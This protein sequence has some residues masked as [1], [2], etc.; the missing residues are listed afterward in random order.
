MIPRSPASR[1]RRLRA[2]AAALAA[3]ALLVLS[4]CGANDPSRNT[5]AVGNDT[6]TQAPAAAGEL[7]VL[8]SSNE[9]NL[10]PAKSQS[11]AVTSLAL[12]HRRLTTWRVE[13]GQEVEVVP[14]LATDTGTVSA[15]GLTWTYTLKDGLFFS[16]GSPITAADIKYGLER[17]YAPALSGG[18]TYHRALLAGGE[19]YTGPYEGQGL[20]SI[21]V[22]DDSTIAFH[23]IQP[24][25]DWPWIVSTPAFSPVPQAADNPESFARE[26]VASG[27]YQVESVNVGVQVNL[28]R[29]EHWSADT[30]SMRTAQPDRI[31]WQLGQDTQTTTQRLL[32]DDP[33]NA[34]SASLVPA[35][36]LAQLA[37]DPNSQDRIV[38]SD[39]GPL[40]Y[41]AINTERVSDVRVRQAISRAVNKAAVLI[42][43][44]GERGG[45]VATTY[46]SPGIPGREEYSL[47]GDDPEGD[48]TG[49]QALLDEAGVSSLDLTLLTRNDADS[50]ARSEAIRQGLSRVGINVTIDAVES[51]T[52]SERATQGDGSTYDLALGSW[53]P[54]YPSPNANL[55]PL[56]HSTEIG[57]GGYNFSR[58]SNPAVDAA[59]DA[60]SAELDPDAAGPMWAAADRQIAEDAPVVPLAFARN[61]FIG[62][63]GVGNYYVE[64]FPAY[65]N[66]LVLTVEG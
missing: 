15:D 32:N 14:D 45:A 2:A 17:T 47:Y 61:S 35:S 64:P 38:T 34:I 31:V 21:E 66:Y 41:M 65:P 6:G 62:G 63:S 46:I 52:F 55:R 49:A 9:L 56:F 19:D 37:S 53:N 30:D 22:I 44:G 27:P 40:Q 39:P 18:L 28:V 13:P 16:D 12:V 42:A 36:T 26:P 25:G 5:G 51:A 50:V 24:E 10:D 59:I 8:S 7:Q 3:G 48:V 60:A 11:M 1:P 4:A 29:N 57:S 43:M 20:D 33:S 58:Y 54:D 23:L